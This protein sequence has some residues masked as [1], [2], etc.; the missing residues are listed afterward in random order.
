MVEIND[1]RMGISGKSTTYVGTLGGKPTIGVK[2][3]GSLGPIGRET[4]FARQ[5]LPGSRGMTFIFHVG[6]G[7]TR[8]DWV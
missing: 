1:L 6:S 7:L 2:F 8:F 4:A 3:H 5:T